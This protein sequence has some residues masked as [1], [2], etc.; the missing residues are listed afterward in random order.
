MSEDPAPNNTHL[1][2]ERPDLVYNI[3]N[4]PDMATPH[5]GVRSGN[6]RIV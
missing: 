3:Q 2:S 5:F 4:V 1:G 6:T